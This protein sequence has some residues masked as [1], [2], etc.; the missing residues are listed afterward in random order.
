MT[1]MM[2]FA[3]SLSVMLGLNL[4]LGGKGC[5]RAVPCHLWKLLPLGYS[6]VGCGLANR[7]LSI[8]GNLF[9]PGSS[10]KGEGHCSQL[11]LEGLSPSPAEPRA[12]PLQPQAGGKAW[13]CI[14]E[15]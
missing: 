7:P 14:L 10:C 9:P 11:A 15:K 2:K 6:P 5:V 12:K 1:F 8:C 3:A 13:H 4:C